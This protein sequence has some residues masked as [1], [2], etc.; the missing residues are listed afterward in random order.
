MGGELFDV[1]VRNAGQAKPKEWRKAWADVTNRYWE[2]YGHNERIDHRSH[3]DKGLSERLLICFYQGGLIT[4]P[5]VQ[6]SSRIIY[7]PA[8]A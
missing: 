4:F 5:Q 3:A 1:D 8:D 2:Q 6:Y 7:H